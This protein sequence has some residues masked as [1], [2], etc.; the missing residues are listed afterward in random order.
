[1]IHNLRYNYVPNCAFSFYCRYFV[2]FPLYFILDIN[3]CVNNN[4]TCSHMCVNTE[5]SYHCVCPHGYH[6]QADNHN[7]EGECTHY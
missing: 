7:C 1:M 5:G 3:E 2:D 6:L 4:G